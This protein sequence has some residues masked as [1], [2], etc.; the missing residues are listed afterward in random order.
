[1]GWGLAGC[2]KGEEGCIIAFTS[3]VPQ[4]HWRE[5]NTSL[6]APTQPWYEAKYSH[7]SPPPPPPQ[8]THTH[9]ATP[10]CAGKGALLTSG[11]DT[12]GTGCPW[13]LAGEQRE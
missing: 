7:I 1:M 12:G 9:T 2:D 10:C 8:H 3:L 6:L 5:G 11:K 13:Q 4:L